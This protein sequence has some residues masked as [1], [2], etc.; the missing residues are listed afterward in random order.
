MPTPGAWIVDEAERELILRARQGE[1]WAFEQLVRRYDRRLLSVV[2]DLTGD[3]GEAQDVL[4]DSL[5][6]AYR[7][8][9]R[10]RLESDLFTWLY[11][12]AVNRALRYRQRR[13]RRPE[14]PG[15]LPEPPAAGPGPEEE[16]LG[17][18]LEH[19]L[20]RALGELSRQERAAFVLCHRQGLAVAQAAA[21]LSCTEGSVKSYLFR[22]RE[23]LKRL[24]G[25]YLE[26]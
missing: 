10:F 3:L 6:A 23:K 4:Q 19:Q 12:I 8:F 1:T 15:A 11:R 5:L 16:V 7:A 14:Q 17:A 25:P 24:L 21:A 20:A 9:P 18:E 13:R 26:G 22:A 2:L